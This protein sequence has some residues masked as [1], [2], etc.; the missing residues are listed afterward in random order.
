[1]FIVR[2]LLS[3]GLH[4]TLP[5]LQ[6]NVKS[7]QSLATPP[8][9]F[10]IE[11]RVLNTSR[12]ALRS[13]AL[14]M[15]LPHGKNSK[16]GI[17]ESIMVAELTVLGRTEIK[18]KLSTEPRQIKGRDELELTYTC[19]ICD[20]LNPF[21]PKTTQTTRH[22]SKLVNQTIVDKRAYDKGS[23]ICRCKW[24]E[25]NQVLADHD[26]WYDPNGE[27]KVDPFT[28]MLLMHEM[29]PQKFPKDL[30]KIVDLYYSDS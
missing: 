2:R 13:V 9:L 20:S 14:T 24:C 28:T 1:M 10:S 7:V 11:P 3:V 22:S 16:K 29:Y 26:R 23:I 18:T 21:R 30:Q 5:Q 27:Y 4:T 17:E 15:K 8:T 19:P 25:D 6:K 12:K